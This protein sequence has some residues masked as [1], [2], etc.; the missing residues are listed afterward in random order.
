MLHYKTIF[1]I[2][3]FV[4]VL[5][6]SVT[7]HGDSL[8]PTLR[9]L[10]KQNDKYDLESCLMTQQIFNKSLC[11]QLGRRLGATVKDFLFKGQAEIE[12]CQNP[13]S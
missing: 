4:F 5:Y 10:S 12:E 11:D 3:A 13:V 6:Y 9:N 7:T 2:F 8:S 1:L